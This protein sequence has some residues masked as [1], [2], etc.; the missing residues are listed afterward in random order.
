MNPKWTFLPRTKQ[1]VYCIYWTGLQGRPIPLLWRLIMAPFA[2]FDHVTLICI[3]CKYYILILND[4][5]L[6]F[7]VTRSH[8]K[9]LLLS[10]QS[11]TNL[12]Y[13]SATAVNHVGLYRTVFSSF[14]YMYGKLRLY[15]W[16]TSIS[17]YPVNLFLC[18]L[19]LYRFIR[20]K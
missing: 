5:K 2:A 6:T 1:Y 13:Q 8:W 17:C 18:L 15:E 3:V 20:W 7:K 4:L 10:V 11:P 19:F 16:V 9:Q 12:F 14:P